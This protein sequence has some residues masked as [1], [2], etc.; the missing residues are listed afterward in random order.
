[1]IFYYILTTLSAIW[2]ILSVISTVTELMEIKGAKIR[3]FFRRVRI[4]LREITLVWAIVI[5]GIVVYI[6]AKSDNTNWLWLGISIGIF[7]IGLVILEYFRIFGIA[8]TRKR[9]KRSALC[10]IK[11]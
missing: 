2:L 11:K 10:K 5:V 6:A 8:Q 9:K 4:S 7:I 3:N 1:M